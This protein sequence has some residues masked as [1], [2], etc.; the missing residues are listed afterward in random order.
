LHTWSPSLVVFMLSCLLA[1]QDSTLGLCHHL[2]LYQMI[3]TQ[4]KDNFPLH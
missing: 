1:H 3:S 2:Y 4:M